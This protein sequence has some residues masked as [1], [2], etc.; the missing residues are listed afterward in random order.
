MGAATG[1]FVNGLAGFGTALFSLGWFLQIAPPAQAV[2]MS[3]LIAVTTGVQGLVLVRRA[4]APKRLAAFLIPALVGI[5]IGYQLL[6]FIDGDVMKLG[7]AVF[8]LA[9]GVF[10]LRSGA[11][12]K[13]ARPTPVIDAGVGFVGGVMGPLCGLSGAVPTMWCA[14]KDWSK[15]ETRGVLQPFN[16]AVLLLSLALLAIEGA[17]TSAMA[18][19]ALITVVLSLLSAQAGI[20]A[21]KR[22][23]DAQ[24]RQALVALMFVSGAAT[25][26]SSFF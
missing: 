6:S 1:G 23:G 4:I 12:P 25:L 8:M 10:F 19:A 18:P 13:L 7:I 20:A 3:I 24:F 21:F 9:Y 26:T 16:F 11:A 14:V 15:L 2:A 5:P 22:L 17:F